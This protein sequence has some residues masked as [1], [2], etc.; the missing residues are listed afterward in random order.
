MYRSGDRFDS[1][2]SW[3]ELALTAEGFVGT[4]GRSH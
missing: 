4:I 1:E 3:M 2:H